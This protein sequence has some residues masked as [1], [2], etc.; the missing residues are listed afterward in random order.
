MKDRI[1]LILK[2][3]L[4]ISLALAFIFVMFT[5]VFSL[6][7]SKLISISFSEQSIRKVI[8]EKAL[9]SSYGQHF[10][11]MIQNMMSFTSVKASIFW[12]SILILTGSIVVFYLITSIIHEIL[13]SFNFGGFG[14]RGISKIALE[15][16][17]ALI[18]L[19]ILIAFI[20][21]VPLQAVWIAFIFYYV[22][23]ILVMWMLVHFKWFKVEEIPR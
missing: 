15:F 14:R 8:T 23:T 17:I 9:I 1:K 5:F 20:T 18:F 22:V 19:G 11:N 4:N 10:I 21:G 16:F 7:N 3:R 6:L 12:T 2:K 13:W